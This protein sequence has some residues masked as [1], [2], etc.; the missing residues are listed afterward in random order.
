MSYGSDSVTVDLLDDA[1]VDPPPPRPRRRVGLFAAL[2]ATA[3]VALVLWP[4]PVP[5]DQE[6]DAPAE[7]AVPPP[8]DARL[9][10]WPGRGPWVTDDAF[11]G[12]AGDV[13]ASSAAITQAADSPGPVVHPLW[14][15][16]V[17]GVDVAILQSVGEDG[18]GRVAQVAEYKIPGSTSPAGLTLSSVADIEGEPVMLSLSYAEGL[19]LGTIL[20]EPGAA[21]VQVLPAPAVLTQGSEL[22]RLESAQFRPVAVQDDGLSEPWVHAEWK[23]TGGPVVAVVRTQV[24]EP[25]LVAVRQLVPGELIPVSAPVELVAPAWGSTRPDIPEDYV[26]AEAALGAVGRASGAA[27]V[28]GSTPSDAGHVSLV[29]V[30]PEADG[31][32]V[33]V[34]VVNRGNS[35]L[36]SNPR[37]SRPPTEV[38]LGAAGSPDGGVVVVAAGPP[39]TTLVVVGAD[40][41]PIGTGPPTTALWLPR[42]DAVREVA[43]QA[44]R[45]DQTLI[46]RST[47]DI[48]DL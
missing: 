29:E 41:A 45:E 9:L 48:S 38:A 13:W 19:D 36:V 10:P 37:P 3:I 25:G 34:T 17:S 4:Q 8:E 21:L 39:G 47:L 28:L 32:P 6:A 42:D 11:V 2:G 43:A 12:Q 30:E 33:V 27:A 15:G 5:S 18:V 44:Y 31:E 46:G 23:S 40:G 22:Q 14:A 16:E 20:D 7:A 24:P 1:P 35:P 26:A